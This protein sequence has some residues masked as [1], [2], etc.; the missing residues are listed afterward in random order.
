MK[1]AVAAVVV[2]AAVAAVPT[3][4]PCN[5][6]MVNACTEKIN[7]WTALPCIAPNVFTYGTPLNLTA[8][9][10]DPGCVAKAKQY[11]AIESR[12]RVCLPDEPRLQRPLYTNVCTSQCASRTVPNLYKW[13][14]L[15]ESMNTASNESTS[16][17]CSAC[18]WVLGSLNDVNATGTCGGDVYQFQNFTARIQHPAPND[19]YIDR[20]MQNSLYCTSHATRPPQNPLESSNVDSADGTPTPTSTAPAMNDAT[21]Y[22]YA[23]VGIIC[24]LCAVALALF[25]LRYRRTRRQSTQCHLSATMDEP[26]A[27]AAGPDDDLYYD[28]LSPSDSM[29]QNVWGKDVPRIDPAAVEFVQLLAQ[30]AN[31][32]VFLGT[33]L[34]Q[35]VAVKTMLPGQHNA[36]EMF[37]IVHEIGILSRLHHPSIVQF[38][39]V[40]MA[41]RQDDVMFLV[42]YMDQGDLRDRLVHSSPQA[43]PWSGLEKPA[44]AAQVVAGLVY[45]HA[46]DI[47]HRDLKSRNILLQ[48]GGGA[49]I[50]DFGAARPVSTTH[51][52]T[53]GVGTYRWMAPEV[54][55]ENQ[56]SVA[57][58]IFSF[59][60]LLTELDT[61]MIPYTDVKSKKSGAPLV[62]TAIVSMVIAGAIQPT[63]RSDC[64]YWLQELIMQCIATDPS[65][66]PTAQAIVARFQQHGFIP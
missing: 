14:G 41:A 6:T 56:Y 5:D 60:I 1:L 37:T 53:R 49:K 21:K 11:S 61:H 42:E 44:I 46:Q 54:L 2:V 40:C 43:M 26:S 28:A 27:S 30:G 16:E 31:G 62:D 24:S 63:V 47:I 64:P 8:F 19:S 35:Q 48:T 36:H 65:L 57:A 23:G 39:G 12:C 33:Y 15:C 50:S 38:V 25:V 18:A 45:L 10:S 66:R 32:Q 22:T 9:C 52:M 58:D 29:M 17:G 55:S 7:E 20:I 51:T 3:P 59:G 4:S 13:W 34:G